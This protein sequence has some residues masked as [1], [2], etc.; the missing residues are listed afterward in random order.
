MSANLKRLASQR[1]DGP[2]PGPPNAATAGAPGASAVSED[3][4]RRKRAQL[5][6]EGVDVNEQIRKIHERYKG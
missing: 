3:E 1:N 6:G 4:A 5:S 2:S